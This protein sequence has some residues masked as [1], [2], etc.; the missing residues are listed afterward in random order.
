MNYETPIC[1]LVEIEKVDIICTS[2]DDTGDT[3]VMP[4]PL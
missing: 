1:E 4:W 3:P 2:T